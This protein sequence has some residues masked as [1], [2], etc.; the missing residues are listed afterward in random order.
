MPA[1]AGAALRGVSASVRQR[2]GGPTPAQAALTGAAISAAFAGA[3]GVLFPKERWHRVAL[4]APT[5]AGAIIA[6][7]PRADVTA[8]GGYPR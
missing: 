6:D 5:P 1:L 2:E 7:R 3:K 8:N 4:P